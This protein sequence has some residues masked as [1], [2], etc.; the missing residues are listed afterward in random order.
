MAARYKP[1]EDPLRWF[2]IQKRQGG[3]ATYEYL[4]CAVCGEHYRPLTY[5][6]HK[7]KPSHQRSLK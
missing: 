4:T 2:R 3:K 6:T 5:K 1:K 7:L